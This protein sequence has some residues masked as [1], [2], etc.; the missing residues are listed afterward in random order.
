MEENRWSK[1]SWIWEQERKK[2]RP[3]RTWAEGVEESMKSRK[4]SRKDS[5]DRK[6][7]DVFYFATESR[8]NCLIR[9]V[10]N[11]VRQTETPIHFKQNG[12]FVGKSTEKITDQE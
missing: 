11:D 1:K 4:L 5:Q 10:L 6:N 12:R 8:A 2:S 7:V 3:R 9:L